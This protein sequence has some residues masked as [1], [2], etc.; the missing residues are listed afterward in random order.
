MAEKP[1]QFEWDDVKASTNVDKHGV[2][3]EAAVEVFLDPD[4]VL[5][6][7]T[8]AHDAEARIKATG[9]VGK[10]LF[11]AVF[12]RRGSSLRLISAR[13]ANLSEERAYGRHLH[14]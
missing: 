2:S 10:K 3:F 8:R 4:L 7:T 5:T 11:T 12:T 9:R 14:P 1:F 13:R 6:D